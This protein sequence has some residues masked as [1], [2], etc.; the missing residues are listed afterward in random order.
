MSIL[1]ARNTP[2]CNANPALNLQ[3]PIHQNRSHQFSF[4]G[5]SVLVLYCTIVRTGNFPFSLGTINVLPAR[6][7]DKIVLV[8]RELRNAYYNKFKT[9]TIS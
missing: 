8:F 3:Y 6:Q 4:I 1:R 2:V 9:T 5:N 7:T